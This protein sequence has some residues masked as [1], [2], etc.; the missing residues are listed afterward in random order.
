MR[1]LTLQFRL[2]EA[3]AVMRITL[4]QKPIYISKER[5]ILLK[6]DHGG[7]SRKKP[8]KTVNDIMQRKERE[9][10]K[11]SALVGAWDQTGTSLSQYG[12][13]SEHTTA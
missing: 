6:S 8:P 9:K 3:Q 1:T 13:V 12:G 11:K 10:K 2:V 7:N 4:V 5:M